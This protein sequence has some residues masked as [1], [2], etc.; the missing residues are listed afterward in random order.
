ME[1]RYWEVGRKGSMEEEEKGKE[2]NQIYENRIQG[3]TETN[4]L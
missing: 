2:G 4:I 1:A 3:K